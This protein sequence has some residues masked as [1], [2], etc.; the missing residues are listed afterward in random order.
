ML[1]PTDHVA[2]KS[3]KVIAR[4]RPGN[5]GRRYPADRRG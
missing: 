1:E 4:S 2:G 5:K 3:D